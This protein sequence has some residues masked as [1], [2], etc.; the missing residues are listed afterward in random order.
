LKAAALLL[1]QESPAVLIAGPGVVSGPLAEANMRALWNLALLSE[2]RL[3]PL[4]LHNNERGAFELWRHL[5]GNSGF[6]NQIREQADAGK[7]KALYLAGDF[8]APAGKKVDIT[9][10]QACFMNEHADYA[11]AVLPA[12]TFAETEGH[13]VNGQ[14]R[15][16]RAD[17]LI[18]PL[19]E[20]RPDW[21]ILCGLARK[22]GVSGF[23][24]S[25]AAE[26]AA[27]LARAFPAFSEM[28]QRP[29]R[30]GKGLFVSEEKKSRPGLLPLTSLAETPGLECGP[31]P[32]PG[33]ARGK[34]GADEA[35]RT[36][37]APHRGKRGREPAWLR[38]CG[39][40]V[41][42]PIF[43]SS[44]SALPGSPANAAP[45]SLS[46]SCRMRKERGFR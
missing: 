25:S 6:Q 14:G 21:W 2:A 27:E 10:V 23:D 32:G 40:N 36:G 45:A 44:R 7:L 4:A 28:A 5:L 41:W 37:G 46:S 16:Q 3:I 42:F 33:F 9:I 17:K 24:F 34:P 30:K 26:I 38:S 39:K 18:D 1:L 43:T 13:Y 20:A 31:L 29:H 11:D 8:L 22:M 19:G 12:A 15:I 35:E